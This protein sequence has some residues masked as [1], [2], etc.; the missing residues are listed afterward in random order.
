MRSEYEFHRTERNGEAD[1]GKTGTDAHAPRIPF[2]PMEALAGVM[3]YTL[4]AIMH[5]FSH[6]GAAVGDE[7][8]D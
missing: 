8:D 4:F 3:S 1:T 7:D 2:T 5:I 6:L